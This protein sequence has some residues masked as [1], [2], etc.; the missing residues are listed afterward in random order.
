VMYLAR[1]SQVVTKPMSIYLPK[2]VTNEYL[3]AKGGN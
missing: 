1:R 3:P 2:V